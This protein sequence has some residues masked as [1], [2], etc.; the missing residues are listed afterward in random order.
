MGNNSIE[1][2]EKPLLTFNA[3]YN[4]LR[5]EKKEKKLQKFPPLFYQALNEFIQEKKE[6]IK[7]HKSQ[8]NKEKLNKEQHILKNSRKIAKE[9]IAIRTQ[10]IATIA[11]QNTLLE[12]SIIEEENI[13]EEETELYKSI[14]QKIKTLQGKL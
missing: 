14:T 13:V 2:Q 1:N 6:E 9:I 12:E 8:G 3:L 11:T 7:T 4:I 5:T 10:K